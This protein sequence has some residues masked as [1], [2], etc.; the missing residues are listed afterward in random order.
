MDGADE[1]TFPRSVRILKTSFPS[2]AEV[3]SP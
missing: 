1:R 3:V 2:S